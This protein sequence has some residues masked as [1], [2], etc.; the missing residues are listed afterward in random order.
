MLP[1]GSALDLQ[2]LRHILHQCLLDLRHR[3]GS[4][5]TQFT[6]TTPKLLLVK[7]RETPR[8]QRSVLQTLHTL[9]ARQQALLAEGAVAVLAGFYYIYSKMLEGGA[10]N[11]SS[12][13]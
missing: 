8:Y 13:C 10:I 2:R 5:L 9:M 12:Q 4:S 6:G 11:G 1:E 3:V 7:L